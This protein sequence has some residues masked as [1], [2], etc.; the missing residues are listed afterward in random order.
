MDDRAIVALY[1]ARDEAAIVETDRA[2]GAFC[3][4]V[5]S[6]LLSIR[7]DA[8]E[9]V[10]DTYHAAW[11]RIPPTVPQSLRA[12]LGVEDFEAQTI[13]IDPKDKPS[14]KNERLIEDFCR[15]LEAD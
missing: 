4:R 14:E 1:F 3:R 7:E 13:L 9:C 10:N 5:A 11:D 2:H 6:N 12:F 15:A 8:E